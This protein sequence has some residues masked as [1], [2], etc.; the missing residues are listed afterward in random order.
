MGSCSFA[1]QDSPPDPNNVA[2]Y[3]NK[4]QISR[5]DKDGWKYGDSD[6]EIVLTGKYC[7]GIQSGSDTD[8]QILFG[9]PGV[10]YFPQEIL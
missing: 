6:K 1:S 4:Q 2:V 9:C 5:S 3:V 7:D 10:T 8:V